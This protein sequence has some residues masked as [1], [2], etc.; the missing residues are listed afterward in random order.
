MK[1]TNN[2]PKKIILFG[3][4]TTYYKLVLVG[5]EETFNRNKEPL[6]GNNQPLLSNNQPLL[7]NNQPVL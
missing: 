2:Y 6:L 3:S 7:S 4:L 1:Q 5:K